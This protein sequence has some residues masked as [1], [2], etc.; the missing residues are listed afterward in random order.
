VEQETRLRIVP[1]VIDDEFEFVN[2][3]P[4]LQVPAQDNE[5]VDAEILEDVF[6][7]LLRRSSGAQDYVEIN[8]PS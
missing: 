6:R 5:V 4:G 2:V 3:L 1:D 8:W 7:V